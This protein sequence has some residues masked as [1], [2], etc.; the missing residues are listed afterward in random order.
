[1]SHR[2]SYIVL[3]ETERYS[4][5]IIQVYAT[6]TSAPDEDIEEFNKDISRATSSE[7]NTLPVCY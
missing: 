3:K 6:I 5:Q 1:M 7:K 2:V 4:I